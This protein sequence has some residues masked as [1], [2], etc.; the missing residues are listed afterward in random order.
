MNRRR[1]LLFEHFHFDYRLKSIFRVG[2]WF[3]SGSLARNHCLTNRLKGRKLLRSLYPRFARRPLAQA[4]AI[5][6]T[7]HDTMDELNQ[8]AKSVPKESWTQVTKTACE[9][10]EKL[11]LPITATTEGV[12]RLIQDKFEQLS[13][14]QKILAAKCLQEAHEK[15]YSN[16][17]K[18]KT[19]IK[20]VVVYEALENTDNQTDET[21]RSL[22]SNLLANEFTD[23]SVHPEIAKLLS[24]LTT[25]DALLLVRIAKND[26]VS[27][28][29]LLLKLMAS[30]VTLGLMDEKKTFSHIHLEKIGLIQHFEKK[31]WCLTTAGKELLKCVSDPVQHSDS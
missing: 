19:I 9:T 25:Q 22:W 18:Q 7:R 17:K 31:L 14:T 24:R 4:L 23:G 27:V 13:E 8:I 21:I 26:S 2:V 3:R 1:R 30:T 29:A 28:P 12:G 15:S 16:I 10:F 6:Y 5:L 20:P 11:I